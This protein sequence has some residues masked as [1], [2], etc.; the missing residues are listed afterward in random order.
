ML[1]NILAE[2][3]VAVASTKPEGG[4]RRNGKK[5]NATNRYDS[6]REWE[7]GGYP[8]FLRCQQF[9]FPAAHIDG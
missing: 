7:G 3:N 2:I 5:L 1:A 4:Q 9:L 6:L 8:A